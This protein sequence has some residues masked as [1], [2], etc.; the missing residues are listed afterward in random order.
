MSSDMPS[1]RSS[2]FPVEW[3][4]PPGEPLSEER[5]QWVKAN[6]LLWMRDPVRALSRLAIRVQHQERRYQ[7]EV[8]R[9]R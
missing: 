4:L 6:T 3:G 8:L 2:D 7:L 5:A 1:T 9:D